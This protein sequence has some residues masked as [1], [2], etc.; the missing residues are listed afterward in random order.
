MD[1]QKTEQEAESAQTA[2]KP[3]K[4]RRPWWARLL[5]VVGWVCVAL[6]VLALLLPTLLSLG[7][8][9]GVALNAVN[10]AIA[11]AKLEIEDWS[12]GWFA[13]QS[14][15][16]V[17]YRDEAK[18]VDAKVSEVRLSSLWELVPVG[19]ITVDVEVESPTVALFTPVQPE[20]APAQPVPEP[21]PQTL[22]ESASAQPTPA[23]APASAA[24]LFRLPDW[25]VKAH[26]V[27]RNAAF[28]KEGMPEPLVSG[29]NVELTVPSLNEDITAKLEGKFL[30]LAFS[31]RAEVPSAN[32]L[33]AAKTP[34]EFM[35]LVEFDAN[36][37]WLTVDVDA[38]SKAGATW[39]KASARVGVDFPLALGVA[40]GF[41]VAL[42]TGAAIDAGKAEVR[43]EVGQ[44]KGNPAALEAGLS[45]TTTDIET[46]LEGKRA[47]IPSVAV[48]VSGL[49]VDPANLLSTAIGNLTVRFPGVTVSGQGSLDGGSLQAQV[50]SQEVLDALEPFIGA[51]PAPGPVRVTLDGQAKDGAFALQTK[52]TTGPDEL[53]RVNLTA[54][55][56]DVAAQRVGDLALALNADLFTVAE[57]LKLKEPQIKDGLLDVAVK[58]RYDAGAAEATTTIRL[59]D[60][61]LAGAGYKL[62]EPS[63]VAG[64]FKARFAD[65]RLDVTDLSLDVATVAHLEGTAAYALGTPVGQAVTAGFTGWVAPEHALKAWLVPAAPTK[66]PQVTGKIA[67]GLTAGP[68]EAETTIPAVKVTVDSDDLAVTLPGMRAIEAPLDVDAAVEGQGKD[69]LLRALS[70]KM[71]YVELAAT[72][73]FATESGVVTAEGTL[74][75]VFDAIW[76]LPFLDKA[77]EQGIA[78]SGRETRPFSLTLPIKGGVEGILREGRAEA[79]MAFARVTVPGLDIPNGEAKATLKDGTAALDAVVALNGGEVRLT[80]RLDVTETGYEIYIP[81]GDYLLKDFNVTT[82]MLDAGLGLVSPILKGSAEPSGT[83]SVQS[84][85]MRLALGEPNPLST[86]DL[87]LALITS[88]IALKP[89]GVLGQVLS[90]AG[91]GAKTVS[92]KSQELVVAVKE[93]TLSTDKPIEVEIGKDWTVACQGKTDLATRAIDYTLSVPLDGVLGDKVSDKSLLKPVTL[94]ITGTVDNPNVEVGNLLSSVKDVGVSVGVSR[95]QEHLDKKRAKAEASGDAKEAAKAELIDKA[96]TTV[97]SG[98]LSG[99]DAE[100]EGEAQQDAAEEEADASDLFGAALNLGG[101]V[102]K[103]K[104]EEAEKQAAEPKTEQEREK[105]AKEEAKREAVRGGLNALRGLLGN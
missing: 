31:A 62:K 47:T 77:R 60:V 15:K 90:A 102:L 82:E 53:A 44:A 66:M 71:P 34:A 54:G 9:R 78:V 30:D 52:V 39:P 85:R 59:R 83:V 95:L 45:V 11:P 87:E 28:S 55:D 75:P 20:P 6:V 13:G 7:V 65:K 12:F 35:R 67:L 8:T 79:A 76:G 57:Y 105:A 5:K 42:P 73:G 26:V 19:Q 69:I 70:V 23:P 94:P 103:E 104:Q 2:Q 100:G 21:Q 61:D 49:T 10:G 48:G 14:V 51:V 58:G 36:A 84:R 27:V 64:A 99:G 41:G 46:T 101:A 92:L 17:H 18:G 88:E 86:L 68:A 63:L 1:E 98:L 93:G 80:P 74:T 38:E 97:L 37:P 25:A 32:A 43:A 24:E 96:A 22:A 89:N 50:E 33:L 29:V 3:V 40:Q 72:G 4:R 91:K 16:G 56:V 81:E